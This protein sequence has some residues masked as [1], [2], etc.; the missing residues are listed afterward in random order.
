AADTPW[1]PACPTPLAY[2]Q[3]LVDLL[4]AGRLLFGTDWPPA[5]RHLSYRQGVEIVR[6]F[7][8]LSDDDRGLI[9]AGTAA[10]VFGI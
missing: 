4:G 9:L 1:D 2:L 6:T 8:D 5:G 7:A 3:R 10:R